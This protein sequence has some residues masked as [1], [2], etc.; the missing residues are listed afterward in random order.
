MAT[1]TLIPVEEYLKTMYHPDCDYVD[2]MVVERNLGETNH[3]WVQGNLV[4]FF[5]SRYRETGVTAIPELRFQTKPTR[6]RIPDVVVT[7]GKPDEQ[8]LTKPPLLCIE[9]LSPEDRI[10]NLNTKIKEYLDFGVPVVWL[11]EPTER[12]IWVYR[13][14]GME[15]AADESIK[16]DGT[17]IVVP[18]SQIFD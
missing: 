13:A 11:I 10:P 1:S 4:T 12:R 6:F 5:R 8:I 14:N 2:G 3:A 16:L 17:D 9:V 15:E 7:R 18:F